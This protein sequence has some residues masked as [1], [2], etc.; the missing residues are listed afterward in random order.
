MVRNNRGLSDATTSLYNK[1][2]ESFYTG[3]K[4]APPQ[5]PGFALSRQRRRLLNRDSAHPAQF[6][7]Y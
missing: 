6:L 2:H 3:C 1:H 5:I 7:Y 4:A